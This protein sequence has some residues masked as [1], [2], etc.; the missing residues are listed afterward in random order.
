MGRG[1]LQRVPERGGVHGSKARSRTVAGA[2]DA[3]RECAGRHVHH[4]AA[5]GHRRL[6][7]GPMKL[8]LLGTGSPI[9]DAQRAGP[10]TLVQSADAAFL[11][12]CGRGVLLRL[13][14]AGV[15]PAMLTAVL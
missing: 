14:A 2:S 8:T 1:P 4:G 3:P 10:S 7:M 6:G 9:P 12:D 5:T 15:L 11:V 13:T